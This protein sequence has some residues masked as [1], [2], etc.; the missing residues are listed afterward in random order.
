[1]DIFVNRIIVGDMG[2]NCYIVGNEES[3]FI[4]DPGDEAEYIINEVGNKKIEFIL[5]THGHIDHIMALNKIKE[6][7]NTKVYISELDKDFLFDSKKNL[8]YFLGYNYVYK[9][10]VEV[11]KD[12]DTIEFKNTK[13]KVISTPGH[14][15]G[16]LCFYINNMLFSGDTLFRQSIG[17]TDF[18]GGDYATLIKSIREKLLKL[19]PDT[20]VYPGHMEET[21]IGFEKDHNPF[22]I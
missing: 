4:I 12:S 16:G 21:T 11:L 15:P 3:V 7:I 20:I 22:L 9:Y 5:L 18:P 13:I 14:T 8:S 17:R 1:M 19:P 6:M 2:V 10:D